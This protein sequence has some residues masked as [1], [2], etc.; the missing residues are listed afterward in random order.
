MKEEKNYI[1]AFIN[2]SLSIVLCIGAFFVVRAL[3]KDIKN[4]LYKST[5]ALYQIVLFE[6]S[7]IIYA[8]LVFSI[9]LVISLKKISVLIKKYLILKRISKIE[10]TAVFYRKRINNLEK[11][12]FEFF[13]HINSDIIHAITPARLIIESLEKKLLDLKIAIEE[14]D[15]SRVFEIINS[16]INVSNDSSSRLTFTHLYEGLPESVEIEECEEILKDLLKRIGQELKNIKYRSEALNRGIVNK[17]WMP[18]LS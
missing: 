16:K 1:S 2:F 6:G 5:E 15:P 12:I 9:A 18:H 13:Y 7:L 17:N 8:C 3:P 14:E 10:Q 4:I 11:Q